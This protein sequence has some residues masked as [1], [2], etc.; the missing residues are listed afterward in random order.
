MD[1]IPGEG[2][3]GVAVVC[4]PGAG[5]AGAHKQAGAAVALKAHRRAAE[6]VRAERAESAQAPGRV[7]G[8]ALQAPQAALPDGWV[9]VAANRLDRRIPIPIPIPVL[10]GAAAGVPGPARSRRSAQ[11]RSER[12][13]ISWLNSLSVGKP[14]PAQRMPIDLR[15]RVQHWVTPVARA[16]NPR[17]DP[18]GKAAHTGRPRSSVHH[19]APTRRSVRLRAP[20]CDRHALRSIADEQSPGWFDGP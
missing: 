11:S 3:A 9:W 2:S 20:G 12:A 16:A 15:R 1:A 10:A 14:H 13:G 18:S 8:V 17:I 5:A 6:A 4:R 7:V 19:G